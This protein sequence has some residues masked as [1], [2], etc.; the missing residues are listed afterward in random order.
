MHIAHHFLFP[1][2]A[3][4]VPPILDLVPATG[5]PPPPPSPQ[6][7]LAARA[8]I[9]VTASAPLVR[10]RLTGGASVIRHAQHALSAIV[11]E[12]ETQRVVSLIHA[13]DR[14]SLPRHMELY[15]TN[16]GGSCT[17]RSQVDS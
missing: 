15:H 16:C 5:T 3:H 17:F 10:D 2:L 1:A 7:A 11:T 6:A 8:F 9:R 4:R 13:L 12:A 14:P